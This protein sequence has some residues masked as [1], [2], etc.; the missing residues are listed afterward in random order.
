MFQAAILFCIMGQ[1]ATTCETVRSE[2]IL[3]RALCEMR[4]E[5]TVHAV[6]KAAKEAGKTIWVFG[7]CRPA[8]ELG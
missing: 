2:P 1:V 5:L 4:A 7:Y 3:P 8:G 6:E